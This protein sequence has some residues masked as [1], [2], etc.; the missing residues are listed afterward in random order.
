MTGPALKTA[1]VTKTL[2]AAALLAAMPAHAAERQTMTARVTVTFLGLPVARAELTSRLGDGKFSLDSS[3][4]SAGLARM[5]DRTKGTA[6]VSGTLGNPRLEPAS[7]QL[8]YRTRKDHSTTMTFSRDRLASRQTL[9]EPPPRNDEWVKLDEGDLSRINDPIS[10]MMIPAASAAEICNRNIRVFDGEFRVDIGLSPSERRLG[11]GEVTCRVSF[12][13]M[14]G[15]RG[16]RS[17]IKFLRDRSRILIAF[18]RIGDSGV[19][20]PVE[21]SIGTQIGSVHVRASDIRFSR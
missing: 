10:A 9:P 12:K 4:S 3:F 8:T 16:T 2:L 1:F 14:S 7:Y 20:G 21:A 13:P 18:A 19:Y 5:F 11:S 6:S 15:Y 17:A